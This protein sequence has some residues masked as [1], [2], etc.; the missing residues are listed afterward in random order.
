M[1]KV[2][3]ILILHLFI[4]GLLDACG[5]EKES[6]SSPMSGE[7]GT[8]AD[9]PS[10]NFEEM[11][12]EATT[13]VV[14]GSVTN[15]V[16]LIDDEGF[17]SQLATIKVNKGLTDDPPNEITLHQSLDYVEKGNN[18]ILIVEKRGADG[19]YY[20]LTDKAVIPVIENEVVSEI[21]GFSGKFTI[22]EF[23]ELFNSKFKS[24]K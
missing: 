9:W 18:Y 6:K 5:V 20:E 1:K 22:N 10:Y 16:K 19:Y 21:P 8:T 3:F 13:V 12:G 4:L 23:V 24:L 17:E 14:I 11:M 7:S 2:F 15:V